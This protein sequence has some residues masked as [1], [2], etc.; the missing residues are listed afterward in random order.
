M[1]SDKQKN[2]KAI[3]GLRKAWIEQDNW[4]KKQRLPELSETEIEDLIEKAKAEVRIE[5]KKKIKPHKG[6]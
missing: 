3:D 1:F 5:R 4:R 2:S 6:K